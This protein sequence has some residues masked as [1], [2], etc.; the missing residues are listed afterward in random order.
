MIFGRSWI[1]TKLNAL[2]RMKNVSKHN[3]HSAHHQRA[4]GNRSSD[5]QQHRDSYDSYDVPVRTS[6]KLAEKKLI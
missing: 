3:Q 4:M 6:L 5:Q 2:F 1:L